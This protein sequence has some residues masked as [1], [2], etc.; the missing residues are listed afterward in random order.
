MP[1][2]FATVLAAVYCSWQ[3][4]GSI[5]GRVSRGVVTLLRKDPDKGNLIDNF[6]PITL[7]N[8]ELNVIDEVAKDYLA[9]TE[10]LN[11][12][13]LNVLICVCVCVRLCN[14]KLVCVHVCLIIVC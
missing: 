7:L 4:T 12:W 2:L 6:R 10:N 8:T 5:P 11:F 14:L 3:Q 13:T 1:D 9:Q